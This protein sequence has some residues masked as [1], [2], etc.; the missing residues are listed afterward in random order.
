[1]QKIR[2]LT[3]L[4]LFGYLA[5]V[6]GLVIEGY[7]LFDQLGSVGS[8]DD[9]FGGAIVLAL[10]V[11]FLHDRSLV[12]KLLVITLSTLGFAYFTFV[13]THGWLWTILLGIAVAAFLIYFFGIRSDIRRDH[14]EWLHF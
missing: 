14:S 6:L 3:F 8:G 1:M 12:M 7:A 4:Q 11:A 10:A 5:L 2:Q 9:M 13:H